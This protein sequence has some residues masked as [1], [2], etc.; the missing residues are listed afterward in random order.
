MVCKKGKFKM[1]K[2]LIDIPISPNEIARWIN[3]YYDWLN[4][5][6]RGKMNL[7][8]NPS[9]LVKAQYHEEEGRGGYFAPESG[10]SEGQFLTILGLLEVY[11]TT[12]DLKW[13]SLAEVLAETT[14][15]ILFRG[16]DLPSEEFSK[17]YI[18]SP[19]WLFN[20]TADKFTAEAYYLDKDVEVVNGKC[21]FNTSYKARKIF[22]VRSKDS[23]LLWENPF[24][25]VV[26]TEYKVKSYSAID[27]SFTLQLENITLTDTVK[28]VYSDMGGPEI[29]PNETY[30]AWP[31][32]R[33]LKDGEIACAIDSLWWSYDCWKAL[34]EITGRVHYGNILKNLKGLIKYACSIENAGDY[35]TTD[36]QNPDP[37][38]TA[39]SYQY[40]DRWP[41]A[42]FSRDEK[43]GA[44]VITMDK[45]SGFVQLGRGDIEEQLSK[46][47]TW[48]LRYSNNIKSKLKV[49]ASTSKAY[50][51]EERWYYF[52]NSDGTGLPREISI[53]QEEFIKLN[54]ILFDIY[55]N[56]QEENT[57]KSDNSSV[58]LD[59]ITESNGRFYRKVTLTR[60]E[61][62][63]WGGYTYLGWAQYEPILDKEV[64]TLPCFNYKASG[65]MNV[66]IQ[67]SKGWYWEYPLPESNVF[68]KI[69]I[70][71]T[72][73]KL[74]EYQM[75][76]GNAPN[77]PSGIIKEFLFDAVS[78][79]AVLELKEVGEFITIPKDKTIYEMLVQTEEER[80]NVLKIYYLR[81]IPLEGYDYAPWVAPFTL[82]TINNLLD[83]WR[84]TP[85]VGYQAPWIWQELNEPV[86]VDTVLTFMRKSQEEYKRITGNSYN[87]FVQV[88][89][90]DRWDSREY[91]EPNT[92]TWNGPDPNT[93]WG[94]FQYRAIETVGRTLYNDPSNKK[95]KLILE[96]FLNSLNELWPDWKQP[97][98]TE[99]HE[100]GRVIC[101]YREP[102]ITALVLRTVIFAL[103]S[104]NFNEE[105]CNTLIK[106][107]ILALNVMFN[108]TP[109]K[110]FNK[111]FV[112]GTWSTSNGEWYMYWGGEILHSL[113][114]LLRYVKNEFYIKTEDG[115]LV[116]DTYPEWYSLNEFIM[117]KTP[118]G[119]MKVE[120]VDI[121]DKMATP[122]RV[123]TEKG[124]RAIKGGVKM[125]VYDLELLKKNCTNASKTISVDLVE[126][127]LKDSLNGIVKIKSIQGNSLKNISPR[128]A[129]DYTENNWMNTFSIKGST[130]YTIFA[131]V[132]GTGTSIIT[133]SEKNNED[134][135]SNWHDIKN[136]SNGD[137][138]AFTFKSAADST[139]F[140]LY[141]QVEGEDI[142]LDNIM[143]LEGNV[144]IK[145]AYFTGFINAV[146]NKKLIFKI[147][148]PGQENKYSKINL[149]DYIDATFFPMRSKGAV[150]DEINETQAIKRIAEDGTVLETPIYRDLKEPLPLIECWKDSSLHIEGLTGLTPIFKLS[151]P[152]SYEYLIDERI[153]LKLNKIT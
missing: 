2:K 64:T 147:Q 1:I 24:A 135:E 131:D 76:T 122:L 53:S 21:T 20:A 86:G 140:K 37:F 133:K 119:P 136:I 66:R 109:V 22:S 128:K 107:C 108:D 34:Y 65:K 101:G 38:S 91:G 99:L 144:S 104:G 102:H 93:H 39:G 9:F 149:L 48:K 56:P 11:K 50:D 58:V 82:N 46:G 106:K 132:L 68:R 41:E 42:K 139:S 80:A 137:S 71:N 12:K 60:G 83:G 16:M 52:F 89:I 100:D 43:D 130:T 55:Y 79:V 59:T 88:F 78:E 105:L 142:Q 36:L 44:I 4:F 23:K 152:V 8:I 116:V 6:T 14:L 28:V 31:I 124:V 127:Y 18:F 17:D 62:E 94:G 32:W 125:S 5:H 98:P 145:P 75:N 97:M 126:K 15:S 70:L 117:V 81:P 103:L 73:F 151:Y 61:E 69:E 51:P 25:E 85:Y 92:F 150:R 40:Q 111:P 49:V 30:E 47:R 110:D 7:A 74:S 26:G 84:G 19:H 114:L 153:D 45:G 115:N 121:N 148:A 123:K 90:W 10:T 3:E 141:L 129:Y 27:N 134:V 87:F 112:K 57:Y 72:S 29:E 54:N 120:L 63:D 95:A 113:A 143:L 33:K 146:E 118:C 35:L 77:F 67:D 13:L 138:I 96:D